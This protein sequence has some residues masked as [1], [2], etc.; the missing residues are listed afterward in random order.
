[1]EHAPRGP[2][3]KIALAIA[4]GFPIVLMR[5]EATQPMSLLLADLLQSVSRPAS[6]VNLITSSRARRSSA[7]V[8]AY[9]ARRVRRVRRS[10]PTG[11]AN[12][13]P[14]RVSRSDTPVVEISVMTQPPPQRL[15]CFRGKGVPVRAWGSG[16][17]ARPEAVLRGRPARRIVVLAGEVR[18]ATR[19][20]MSSTP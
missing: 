4:A 13:A 2:I 6:L 1:V 9:A 18:A 15:T 3:R 17:D 12:S 10:C 20:S 8:P 19:S 5:A 11:T 14:A 7:A 16:G